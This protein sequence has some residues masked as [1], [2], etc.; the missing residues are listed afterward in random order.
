[1]IACMCLRTSLTWKS[2]K[3]IF[4]KENQH[5]NG[6]QPDHAYPVLDMSPWN[7]GNGYSN[8]VTDQHK[9]EVRWM[10]PPPRSKNCSNLGLLTLTRQVL[11]LKPG[12]SLSCVSCCWSQAETLATTSRVDAGRPRSVRPKPHE[13]GVSRV[14]L[15]VYVTYLSL[16]G[17]VTTNNGYLSV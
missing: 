12:C 1:M 13:R 10:R 9:G 2:G 11:D 3:C 15:L 8:S 7:A 16:A 6:G 4:C 14:Q 5:V 17:R